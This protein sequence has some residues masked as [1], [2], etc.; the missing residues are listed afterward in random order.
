MQV[1]RNFTR[2]TLEGHGLLGVLFGAV[3]YVLCL[4]GA[5]LV[6]VD[7]LTLWETPEAPMVQAVAPADLPRLAATILPIVHSARVDDLVFL[8]MP[9]AE[10]P[11]LT[12][13]GIGAKGAHREWDIDASGNLGPH[14]E[15]HWVE[16]LQTLHFN[17]TLPGAIGRYVVGLFGTILLASLVTGILAHRRILK[18]AFRLRWGGTRRLTNADLHNRIGV[19]ALPFHLIVALTG[20]LLG[21]AGLITLLLALVAFKGDQDRAVA[22]LLG[23]QA[24]NSTTLAPPPPLPEMLATLERNAPGASLTQISFE[25]PE[26]IGQQTRLV[27]AA[28]RHLARNEA[29]LFDG[30]GRL[31]WK[32]GLTDG[33][34]GARIFGMITPLHYGTYGGLALKIIYTLLGTGLALIV[35]TG[36][37]IWLARRRDQGRVAPRLENLWVGLIWGQPLVLVFLAFAALLIPIPLTTGY[38]TGTALTLGASLTRRDSRYS[39]TAFQTAL[40]AALVTLA[41]VHGVNHIGYAPMIYAVDG[42]LLIFGAVL[43]LQK[44]AWRNV[45]PV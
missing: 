16:F 11:R 26:R 32:S 20:S 10:L 8:N 27:T 38:W 5:I 41:V 2:A 15:A 31:I 29:Y 33:N 30:A 45:P 21:L 4:T 24:G 35:A 39:A 6:L 34:A 7:Q 13:I 9:T 23:P 18:D 25:H 44:N 3:I 12:V 19:W 17:L 40:G 43:L 14:A 1:S 36:G 37:N 42:M 22:S 28:P